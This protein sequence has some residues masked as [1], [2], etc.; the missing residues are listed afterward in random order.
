MHSTEIL[1]NTGTIRKVNLTE[2]DSNSTAR[3][4]Q[5]YSAITAASYKQPSKL[6]KH[7]TEFTYRGGRNRIGRR[8][9]WPKQSWEEGEIGG[10]SREGGEKKVEF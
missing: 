2:I 10:R 1:L 4:T 9:N 7:S 8:E 5:D 6:S 3:E